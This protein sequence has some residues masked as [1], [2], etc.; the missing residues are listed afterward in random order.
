MNY[1][2]DQGILLAQRSRLEGLRK[3]FRGH[4]IDSE[5]ILTGLLI[6][7]GIAMAIWL[8]SYL[9]RL[10]EGRR[11][12]SSPLWLFFSLCRAHRLRWSEGWLLWR[13]ARAQRLS[14]AARVFL[15][16]ERL[17]AANLG[18]ALRRRAAQLEQLRERL[19]AR[20]EGRPPDQ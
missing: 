15:E 12:Y 11:A 8:L 10:Q 18:P 19:S 5:E 20:P 9:L 17:Q 4:R 6:L 14:D 16:P 7:G 1:W 3:G 13:V 2:F